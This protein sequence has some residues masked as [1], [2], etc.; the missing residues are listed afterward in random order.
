MQKMN[1]IKGNSYETIVL[2]IVTQVIVFVLG[3][4]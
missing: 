2:L 3:L 1:K 4:V